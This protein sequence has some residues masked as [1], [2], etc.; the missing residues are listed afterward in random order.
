MR[1]AG[2]CKASTSIGLGHLIRINT[3]FG[4]WKKS[5][6]EVQI[7]LFFIG[8]E[9]LLKLIQRE[10]YSSI[11]VISDTESYNAVANYDFLV[12]DLTDVNISL[13]QTFKT[14]SNKVVLLSPVFSHWHL[15]DF[16]FG[17]TKYIGIEPKN[18]PDLTIHTG[19]EFA[20]IQDSCVKISAGRFEENLKGNYFPV[21]IIMG[22]GDANNKTLQILRALKNCKVPATFWVMLGE[23]YKHSLDTLTDEIRKDT[24]H[25]IILAKSN[26]SMWHILQ[27]CLLGI[28]PGGITTYEAV[29][30][31]LPTI[32]F[33]EDPTQQFLIKEL[34]E[35]GAVFDFGVFSEEM[36]KDMTHFIEKM[37][38]N[39]NELLVTHS[40]TKNLI[41]QSGTKTIINTLTQQL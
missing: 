41:F 15:I 17:R 32:N 37:Y 26:Q 23:G 35:A 27:N 19:L 22:G 5:Q 7:D 40:K 39:R 38:I 28:L 9:S 34:V 24:H 31:G 14:I 12:L 6:N 33:Y 8:E 2:I 13:L 21:G 1:I 29:Y 11:E 36:L 25:E 18:F 16:Y 10:Y 4:Q 30:A 20:I 3:F